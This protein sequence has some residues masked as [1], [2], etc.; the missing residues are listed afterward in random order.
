MIGYAVG[1]ETLV[2]H[3]YGAKTFKLCGVFFWQTVLIIVYNF[4]N[5]KR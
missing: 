4:P 5:K 3:A 1:L 2:A